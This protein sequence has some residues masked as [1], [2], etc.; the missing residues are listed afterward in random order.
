MF[1]EINMF[2]LVSQRA[3][4][5]P[6]CDQLDLWRCELGT[7]LGHFLRGD[8]L[9]QQAVCGIARHNNGSIVRASHQAGVGVQ[10]QTFLC[11]I[12]AMTSETTALEDR[13][14]L[15]CEAN[16]C[17]LWTLPS[18]LCGLCLWGDRRFRGDDGVAGRWK[19]RRRL[20]G[21]VTTCVGCEAGAAVACAPQAVNDPIT[22]T[23]STTLKYID[24]MFCLLL[25]Q[26]FD[27]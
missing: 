14:N 2:A 18:W 3:L 17:A 25:K 9:H 19:I 22:K 21:S 11:P 26:R 23:N 4:V 27:Y 8:H 6:I 16:G 13:H 20:R 7:A 5:D 12:T 24:L 10:I 15:I 1:Y